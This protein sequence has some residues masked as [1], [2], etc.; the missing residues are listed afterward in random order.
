[1][2]IMNTS[3][4]FACEFLLTVKD[5]QNSGPKLMSLTMKIWLKISL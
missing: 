1:M 5:L 3:F 4:I 2:E